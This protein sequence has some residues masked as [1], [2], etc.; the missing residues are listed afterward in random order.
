MDFFLV[1]VRVQAGDLKIAGNGLLQGKKSI[2]RR[3][4]L[5]SNTLTR[6]MGMRSKGIRSIR[7][8]GFAICTHLHIINDT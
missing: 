3:L 6:W 8:C 2:Q 7:S 5:I 4:L 1:K